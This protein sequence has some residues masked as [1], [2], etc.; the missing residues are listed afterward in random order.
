MGCPTSQRLAIASSR[1]LTM[2]S[3]LFIPAYHPVTFTPMT[4]TTGAE[5]LEL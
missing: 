4:G 1:R 5:R 2:T 3:R